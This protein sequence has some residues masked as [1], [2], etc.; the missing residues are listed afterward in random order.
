MKRFFS[1]PNPVNDAAA[2]T[3]ALGVV[4]MSVLAL[5]TQSAWLLI[6]LTYGFLARVAAGPKIS[7]LGLFATRIAAPRLDTWTKEVPG[8]PKRFA[9]GIGAVLTFGATVIW[10]AGSWSLARWLLVPLIGAASLEGFLGFC[11]G[12]TIFGWLIRAGVVPES[13]CAEC[14]DLRAR[15][16]AA[17]YPVD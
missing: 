9:Q 4:A 8:P 16:A 5:L 12:C 17:G 3:V 7:P 10:L 6:P 14:G 13:I 1:F 2:R 15:Y 11:V